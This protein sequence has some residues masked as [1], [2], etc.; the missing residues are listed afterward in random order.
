VEFACQ[1]W[2]DVQNWTLDPD[3]ESIEI[4]GPFA[5]GARGATNSRAS[6]LVEWRIAEI[7]DGRAVIEFPLP[8]AMGR[9]VWT[10][11]DCAGLTRITQR[12][13]LQGEQA[14]NYVDSV[15][16]GLQNGIPEGMKKLCRTMENAARS[17]SPST[18]PS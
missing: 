12:W 5:Q 17:Q 14:A 1:F 10:F 8:G 4:S 16:P 15:A 7:D 2:T 3:V 11:E 6:G 9:C 13:S 18:V